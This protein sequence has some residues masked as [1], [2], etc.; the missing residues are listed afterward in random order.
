MF[1]DIIKLDVWRQVKGNYSLVPL[2]GL[3]IFCVTIAFMS[4][5]RTLI[6]SPDV[7]IDRKRNP[8]PWDKL[9]RPDGSPV[10]YKLYQQTPYPKQKTDF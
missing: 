2:V 10:Q 5:L 1:H 8:K 7:V 3:N 4:G 9:I 6:K